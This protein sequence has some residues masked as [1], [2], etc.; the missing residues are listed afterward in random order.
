M[1]RTDKDERIRKRREGRD[2]A[3]KILFGRVF[4][5]NTGDLDEVFEDTEKINNTEL[6]QFTRRVVIG[7]ESHREVIDETIKANMNKW[8]IERIPKVSLTA[9]RI[10]VYEMI[11]ESEVPVSVSINEA[12][13]TV[14]VYATPEDSAFVNAVLGKIS[15]EIKKSG[16]A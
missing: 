8:T 16:E 3:F 14:K 13:E 9:M 15:R 1:E 12:V 4:K 2:M 5:E 7:V 10:A 11:F 6:S